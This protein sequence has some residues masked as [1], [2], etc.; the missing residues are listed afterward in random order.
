[1]Q[2]NIDSVTAEVYT[3][4]FEK[5]KEKYKKEYYN[6]IREGKIKY[7]ERIKEKESNTVIFNHLK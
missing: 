2:T 5:I 7:K 3:N 4:I 6:T 1:L